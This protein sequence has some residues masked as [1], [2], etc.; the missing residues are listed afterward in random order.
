MDFIYFLVEGSNHWEPN[1]HV[2]FFNEQGGFLYG[3]LGALIIGVIAACAFYFGCCNSS[4]SGKSAN[5]GVWSVVLCVCGI[6]SYFYA[7]LFIIGA[8][9]TEDESSVFRTYSFYNANT[10]FLISESEGAS[11]SYVAELT[12]KYNDIK[13]NLDQ[14]SDVRF[15]F[16]ITTALL[17]V[18]CYFITSIVVKRFTINGKTIPFEK[19]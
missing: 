14:G 10:Q 2:N 12:N 13:G 17:A 15:E 6:I 8:S 7:D 1:F 18:I 4:K 16:D 3:A 5:I 9:N 11:P 19:P